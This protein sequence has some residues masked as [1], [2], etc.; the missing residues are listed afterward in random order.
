MPAEARAESDARLLPNRRRTRAQAKGYG[1]WD[2]ERQEPGKGR[3]PRFL[4][5]EYPLAAEWVQGK[6]KITVRFKATN[7][8]EIAP[9]GLWMIRSNAERGRKEAKNV[10]RRKRWNI[11]R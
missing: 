9:V 2:G 11:A 10:K 4:D 3:L 1:G 7:R 6:T 8:N 5:V